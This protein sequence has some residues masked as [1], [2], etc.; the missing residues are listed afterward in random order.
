M[1][2]LTMDRDLDTPNSFFVDS[3]K[4]R[5]SDLPKWFELITILKQFCYASLEI[6]NACWIRQ[7][8]PKKLNH[9]FGVCF[10]R[11]L[12]FEYS[13]IALREHVLDWRRRK[14]G[15]IKS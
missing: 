5:K 12:P 8:V 4:E 13:F 2:T 6:Q 7:F 14:E 10:C 1:S 15:W 9:S 3:K 11:I